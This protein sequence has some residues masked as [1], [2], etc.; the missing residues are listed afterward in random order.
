[1]ENVIDWPVNLFFLSFSFQKKK[2]FLFYD[3]FSPLFSSLLFPCAPTSFEIN[4]QITWQGQMAMLRQQA[5]AAR[6]HLSFF[7]FILP[8]FLFF[9]FISFSILCFHILRHLK[10]LLLH[11]WLQLVA[12]RYIEYKLQLSCLAIQN[13][14]LVTSTAPHRNA[15]FSLFSIFIFSQKTIP[16]CSNLRAQLHGI[17]E[18]KMWKQIE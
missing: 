11:Q 7:F 8:S 15:I 16:K 2:V 10:N 18:N 6:S 12:R 17:E 9:S 3:G 4:I 1:M 13:Q 5:T 14:Q